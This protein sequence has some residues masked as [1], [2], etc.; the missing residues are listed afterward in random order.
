MVT[1]SSDSVAFDTSPRDIW[2]AGQTPDAALGN[3]SDRGT[4]TGARIPDEALQSSS[5]DFGGRMGPQRTED[6]LNLDSDSLER[7]WKEDK[8]LQLGLR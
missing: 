1:E 8:D 3:G 7:L 2:S 5:G 4:W 6:A